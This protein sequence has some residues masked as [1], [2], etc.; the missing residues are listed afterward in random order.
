MRG[1]AA[2]LAEQ[3]PENKDQTASVDPYTRRFIGIQV[4]ATLS[5]MLGA[6]FGVLLI[7]CF[8]VTNLQLARAAERTREM[9]VRFALGASRWRVVRQLLVEGLLIS[10]AGALAGLAIARTGIVLFNNAIVDTGPPFWLDIR[11]EVRVLGFV[12]ALTAIA[13]LASSLI[14]ALRV[15]R[16]D[17]NEIL[18]DEGRS[19]TGLRVGA[20]SRVLVVVQMT[21]SFVLLVVSG[22]MI[23]SVAN[24][25]SVAYP[26]ETN[27]LVASVNVPDAEYTSFEQ[28]HEIIERLRTRLATVPGVT[29]IAIATNPPD[30]GGT[31]PV[32]VEGDAPV[33]EQGNRPSARLVDISTGYFDV[34]R[35][36][37]R[38]GRSVTAADRQGTDRV[39]I[40]NEAF[41]K[42]F[43]PKGDAL[44]KRIKT[45][46]ANQQELRT[47]VGIVPTLTVAQQ[48][49]DTLESVY[50]PYAQNDARFAT[51]FM[52]SGVNAATMST[53][54]RRA[55]MDVDPDLALFSI[56]T[57][58]NL[59]A[60]RS[61]AFKVF[62]GL[63]MTFGL[64]AL[65]M[66]A[67][68]LYGVMSFAVRRRTQEIGVR[69][70]LAADRRSL[71]RMI[72]RQGVWQVG[73]GIVLGFGLGGLLGGAMNQL[74]FRVKPWDPFVFAGTMA[75][76]GGAGLLASYIPAMRAASVDPL[77]ALRQE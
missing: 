25:T 30:G 7:A 19:N 43:F 58:D 64:A 29:N 10:T 54:L 15:A 6:V 9:A 76:L 60:Q 40:V 56:D 45:G 26:F 21:F 55:A 32:I 33:A 53:T 72:V 67:A 59:Y 3:H 24:V 5:T 48:T 17:V 18:K 47:I 61:W 44:G 49:G 70:A 46:P 74:L 37:M 2:R 77:K 51:F 1:I 41:V 68:G 14:P 39:A 38:E 4:I 27:V 28:A 73:L 42:R 36:R 12:M 75:V 23:K 13:A 65:V 66:S 52:S 50:S 69:M 34:I 22:L 62:G 8:N 71:T 57:L 20:F 35:V 16:Q 63:F 31:Y 11:L